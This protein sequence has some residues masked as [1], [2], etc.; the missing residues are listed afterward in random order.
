MVKIYDEDKRMPVNFNLIEAF[1][2]SSLSS[3]NYVI[4]LKIEI[5]VVH[6]YYLILRIRTVESL[7]LLSYNFCNW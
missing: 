3:L 5:V 2:L 4:V 1:N 7:Y 6:V